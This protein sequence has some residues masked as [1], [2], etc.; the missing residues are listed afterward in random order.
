MKSRILHLSPAR[1]RGILFAA[2]L[3]LGLVAAPLHFFIAPAAAQLVSARDRPD[4]PDRPDRSKPRRF[5]G[6]TSSQPLA[7]TADDAFLVVANPDNNSVT[8][9]DVSNDRN[10]DEQPSY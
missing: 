8:F 6:P 3:A 1:R 10:R 9:F 7:L 5:T 2:V 4:R